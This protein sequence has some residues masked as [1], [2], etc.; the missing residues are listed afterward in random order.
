MIIDPLQVNLETIAIRWDAK[1]TK[2]RYGAAEERWAFTSVCDFEK[3]L[4][5]SN[6]WYIRN[7]RVRLNTKVQDKLRRIYF[8]ERQ[9]VSL[10]KLRASSLLAQVSLGMPFVSRPYEICYLPLV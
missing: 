7:V 8:R 3:L 1:I 6:R 9:D 4:I 2:Q 10:S 5:V